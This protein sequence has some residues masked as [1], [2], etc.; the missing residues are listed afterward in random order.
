MVVSTLSALE[1]WGGWLAHGF[2]QLGHD[3]RGFD[4]RK[5]GGEDGIFPMNK[6]LWKAAESFMPDLTVVV[7][8][9]AVHPSTLARI[10]RR[11]HSKVC[12][13]ANDDHQVYPQVSAPLGRYCDLVFTFTRGSLE[14]YVRDGI[15]AEYMMF[16]ADPAVCA[17]KDMPKLYDV[18]FVGTYYPEREGIVHTLAQ[19]AQHRKLSF[20]LLGDGWD[21]HLTG[22]GGT[23]GPLGSKFTYGGRPDYL[24]VLRTWHSS[25]ICLNIH[26]DGLR[27]LEVIANLRCYELAACGSFMLSDY[28]DGMEEV[29]GRPLPFGTWKQGDN[30]LEA[31]RY[32]AE[33]GEERR[34]LSEQF[35]RVILEKH[36]PEHR[37]KHILWR[38]GL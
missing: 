13:L 5:V 9:E 12:L 15:E 4:Y 33:K 29:F 16:Y 30:V 20:R 21:K 32:W 10:R 17:P 23:W 34:R 19:A 24:E 25:K 1:N 36:T 8:G 22:P 37:A 14:W 28:V 2:L 11:T 7:K 38:L 35:R 31:I 6:K 18:S 27:R 26:Q 3:V